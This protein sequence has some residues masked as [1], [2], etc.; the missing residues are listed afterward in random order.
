MNTH[1]IYRQKGFTLTEALVAFVIVT[2][3]LLAIASFQAQL[4]LSSGYSKARTEALS[5]AQQ[6]IEEFKHYT[7][8][9]EDSFIDSDGDGVMDADGYY[10]DAPIEGQNALFTRSWN[11]T[12][13]DQAPQVDVTVGCWIRPMQVSRSL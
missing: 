5:L 12:T 11:L 9:D 1:T 6:K 8:A 10:M 4:F 13:T 7:H 2:G 3:G